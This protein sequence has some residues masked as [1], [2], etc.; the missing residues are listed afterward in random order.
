ML[1]LTFRENPMLDFFVAHQ[2]A[3]NSST[4]DINIFFE[5]IRI[6]LNDKKSQQVYKYFRSGDVASLIGK[7][8]ENISRFKDLGVSYITLCH[9]GDNDICDSA[10][11]NA[12]WNG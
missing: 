6:A 5:S 10:K 12:E 7:D 1:L 3:T 8:L 2:T 4:R 11:G 9:N